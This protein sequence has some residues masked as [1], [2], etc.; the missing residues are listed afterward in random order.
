MPFYSD[1]HAFVSASARI[2][3]SFSWR[4][5]RDAL[6]NDYINVHLDDYEIIFGYREGGSLF[7]ARLQ[8]DVYNKVSG[9][10][11]A[12]IYNFHVY[13]G[14]RDDLPIIPPSKVDRLASEITDAIL[15]DEEAQE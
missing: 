5:A 14:D 8:F 2:A 3:R 15:R 10:L 7:P 12:R 11:V 1:I 13:D 9:D 4:D 6:W